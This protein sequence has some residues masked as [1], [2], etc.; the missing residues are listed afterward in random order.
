[1]CRQPCPNSVP[2]PGP[3]T[4]VPSAAGV[5]RIFSNSN[6]ISKIVLLCTAFAYCHHEQGLQDP[7]RHPSHSA[8]RTGKTGSEW[9]A[10]CCW[11]VPCATTARSV[12]DTLDC[13]FLQLLPT[14]SK[15]PSLK[16]SD[17]STHYNFL[18][19][20]THFWFMFFCSNQN[21]FSNWFSLNNLSY[22][23][24]SFQ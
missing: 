1:M 9:N 7:K 15:I 19:L 4:L 16:L 20:F 10:Y 24:V 12:A 5:R 14:L 13:L 23:L 17:L 8:Q 2:Q 11:Q 21:V 18:Y 3:Q 22:V 6:S